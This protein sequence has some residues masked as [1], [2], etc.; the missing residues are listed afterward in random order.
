M[1][2][3][4]INGAE[5]KITRLPVAHGAAALRWADRIKGGSTRVRTHGGAAGS[6][7]TRMSTT[8]SALGDVK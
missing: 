1:T 2:T 6:S 5:F 7:A 8:A 3:T 4:T